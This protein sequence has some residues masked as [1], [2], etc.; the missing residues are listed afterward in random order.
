MKHFSCKATT[1]QE[2][3]QSLRQML[4]ERGTGSVSIVS[5]T[6]NSI[7][8]TTSDAPPRIQQAVDE[9]CRAHQIGPSYLV[10]ESYEFGNIR[11]DI[12]QTEYVH[13]RHGMTDEIRRRLMKFV[14]ETAPGPPGEGGNLTPYAILLFRG[15]IPDFWTNE[16]REEQPPRC[17]GC[18]KPVGDAR[19]AHSQA[20]FGTRIYRHLE[21]GGF[22]RD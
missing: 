9:I 16:T 3:I 6:A 8:V 18:G 7:D 14:Q 4:E 19:P 13:S 17:G 15:E 20:A 5:H 22:H 2:V 1:V 11:D 12:P 10:L 21:C